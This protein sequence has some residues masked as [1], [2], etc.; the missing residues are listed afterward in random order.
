MSEKLTDDTIIQALTGQIQKAC[1]YQQE[2]SE[3]RRVF[4]KTYRGDPYP[5]DSSLDGWAKTV[6]PTAF[7]TVEWIKPYLFEIFTGDFFSFEGKND[8]VASTLKEYVRQK[9]FVEQDGEEK[10]D[11]FLHYCLTSHYGIFKV[12]HKDDY[13]D[14]KKTF[15]LLHEEEMAQLITLDDVEVTGYDETEII[16]PATGNATRVYENV[17]VKWKETTYKGPWLEVL[18]PSELY[19]LPGYSNT[20][21]CPFVAHV[22]RRTLDYVKRREV[23]GVYRKGTYTKAKDMLENRY[24]TEDTEAELDAVFESDDLSTPDILSYTM[25]TNLGNNEV[26]VC[27]IYCKLDIDGDGFTEPCIVTLIDWKVVAR[28]PIENPYRTP[29]FVKGMIYREP[30]KQVGRPIPDLMDPWQRVNT[31]MLRALQNAAA[32]STR[33]GFMTNDPMAKKAL[34]RWS[35]GTVAHLSNIT[36]LSVKQIDFGAPNQFILKTVEYINAEAQKAGGVN[37]S[38][39]GLDREAMNHTA[40]G[41]A[42][43]LTASQAR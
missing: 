21:D 4:Y 23:E 30:H 5:T 3:K 22:T 32:L 31:N 2:L 18:H 37:E 34:E 13:R 41:M 33:R 43:K 26:L 42:M 12:Y 38:M 35:P 27:E 36:D 6:H 9:L 20:A 16:D 17:K 29:P 1:E 8:Q 19:E 10:I 28:E 15:D 39:M 14:R 7:N 24:G 25:P 40:R 11:D